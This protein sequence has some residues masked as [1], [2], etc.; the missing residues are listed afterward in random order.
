MFERKA[1]YG[2]EKDNPVIAAVRFHAECQVI[3]TPIIV[4][5]RDVRAQ[6]KITGVD[7]VPHLNQINKAAVRG[8]NRRDG[9]FVRPGIALPGG[10]A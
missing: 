2:A 9:A 10:V 6:M 1:E 3:D 4:A 5:R 7:I 8:A